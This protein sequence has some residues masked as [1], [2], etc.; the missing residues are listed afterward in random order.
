MKYLFGLLLVLFGYSAMATHNRAGDITY[1]WVSGNTY[2]FKVVTCTK[3]SAPADRQWIPINWGDGT[4]PDSIERISIDFFPAIDAQINTYIKQHTFPGIGTYNILV[5]DPN[6]NSDVLNLGGGISVNQIFAIR[7]VLVISP[8]PGVG[9]NNS[10][11][12]LAPPKGDACVFTKWAHNPAAYDI[13]GDS[14][15][16]SLTACLGAGGAALPIYVDPDQIVPGPNNNISIDPVTG[17]VCWDAPQL[18]GLYNIAILISEYRKLPNGQ[19]VFVGSVL[20]DMQIDVRNCSNI[21]PNLNPIPNYCVEAGQ[22]LNFQIAANDP[23]NNSVTLSAFGGPFV[24]TNTPAVFVQ[25]STG[26]N[27][28]GTFNWNTNCSHVRLAPYQVTFQ[29]EDNNPTGSLATFGTTNITVVAP[30]PQNPVAAP[31]L[32]NIQL[33]WDASP[34]ANAIGYKVYRRVNLYGF[35]PAFCETGVP[36][37]TGYSLLA[38]LP[39]ISSTSYLDNNNIAFGTEYCYMVIAYFDDGAE[40]YASVEFCTSILWETPVITKNSVGATDLTAGRDTLQWLMPLELDTTDTFTGPYRIE[41]YRGDGFT[42][43]QTLI[44]S[45]PENASLAALSGELIVENLNT[46]SQANAYRIDLFSNNEP[47]SSSSVASSV[48]L[49]ETPNDQTV[50]LTWSFNHPWQNFSYDVYK[51]DAALTTWNLLATTELP[52]YSD[53]GLINGD[54]YCYYVVAKGS[55]FSEFLTDTLINYSQEICSTPFDN[56]PPCPPVLAIDCDC[57]LENNYL[58]WTNTNLSCESTDDTEVYYIYYAPIEGE[59]LMLIDSVFG[60]ENIQLTHNFNGSIAGCYAITALDYDFVNDRRNESDMSNIVCCDNCPEYTLPNV[61]TP[62]GDGQ[63]DTFRPFPYRF[64][65]SIEMVIY[66]RWGQVVFETSDPDIGWDG[67]HKD[68]GIRVPDG[69]YFYVVLVNTIRLTGIVQFELTG[70]VT[71]LDSKNVNFK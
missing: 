42:N 11:Q 50:D 10:V 71:L 69:V 57:D 8:I 60:A 29:A 18:T 41:I 68:A 39:G 2:E 3:T 38:T 9:V 49:S 61:I 40:S 47:V 36:A 32:G 28:T 52:E 35:A 27:P 37:Y 55:Y 1:H 19:V 48:F 59:E 6:R 17:T 14:L 21:P 25:N 24:V 54:E 67:T 51:W 70:N 7:T 26:A 23:D 16:Y 43:P 33:S 12:L 20:R 15:V 44:F 22:N 63:N 34:C 64:V 66:N 46:T 53:T 58:E 30:A 65:E 5:E 45:S 56:T 62:N 31:F 13:D 4:P